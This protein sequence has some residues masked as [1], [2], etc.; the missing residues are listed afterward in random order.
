MR[1]RIRI[2]KCVRAKVAVVNTEAKTTVLLWDENDRGRPF[3]NRGLDDPA[4]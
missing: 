3:R 4:F 2:R 1:K